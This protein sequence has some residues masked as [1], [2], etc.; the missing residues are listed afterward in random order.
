MATRG[1]SGASLKKPAEASAGERSRRLSTAL[2]SSSDEYPIQQ[3]AGNPR[4]PAERM[5][6]QLDELVASISQMGVLQPLTLI[7]VQDWLNDFPEDVEHFPTEV[8]WVIVAGHRRWAAAQ[9]AGLATVPAVIRDDLSGRLDEILLH[10]NLH[11]LDL[12]PLQEAFAF[13]RLIDRPM[14]QREVATQLGVSQSQISKRLSLF[15][16][17]E[18]A[19]RALESGSLSIIE[20]QRWAKD[21]PAPVLTQLGQQWDGNGSPAQALSAAEHAVSVEEAKALAEAAATHHGVP[22]VLR[23]DLHSGARR[24]YDQQSIDA[25]KARGTL[26]VVAS[27]AAPVGHRGSEPQLYSNDKAQMA[28]TPNDDEKQQR[29]ATKRRFGFLITAATSVPDPDALKQ[30]V[31]GAV[32]ANLSLSHAAVTARAFRLA[33]EVGVGPQ[34]AADHYAWAATCR[35]NDALTEHYLWLR[36]LAAWEEAVPPIHSR[37]WSYVAGFYA[38]LAQYGHEPTEWEARRLNGDHS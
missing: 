33:K 25:A 8:Q 26:V 13:Q 27:G 38:L 35:D 20:A 29:I 7:T 22:L 1:I 23:K 36:V 2:A 3:L 18:I 31:Y 11:R 9:Q 14:S 16:L 28:A 15:R 4:N 19:L 21:L 37:D 24:C 5:S 34:D 30:A 17:P 32:L 6:V 12:T 10:E